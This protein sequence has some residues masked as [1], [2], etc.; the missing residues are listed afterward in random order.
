MHHGLTPEQV[1][2]VEG[3]DS[4]LVAQV[5]MVWGNV[6]QCFLFLSNPCADFNLKP[7]KGG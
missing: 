1:T 7:D 6:D 5:P 2:T 3:I 4:T